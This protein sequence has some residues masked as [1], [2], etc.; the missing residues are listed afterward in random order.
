M[1]GHSID[2]LFRALKKGELSG[3]Y[4]LHG[5]E[6]LLKDEAIRTILDRALDPGLRDFNF[7]QRSA[8]QLDVEAVV[9]LCA[10]LPMMAD[11]RVVVIRDVEAWKRKPKVRA[12]LLRYLEK[13]APETILVLVQS[14][15]EEAED[16]ELG[17]RA[18]AVRFD[19]LPPDRALKWL[20]HHA[21]MLG[22]ALGQQGAEHLLRCVGGELGALA[23]ELQK[24]AA[25]PPGEPLT[26]ERVSELVGVRH[27]ETIFDWRDRVMDD[28]PAEAVTLLAPV[29]HQPGVSAVKLIA[30]LGTTLVG[31]GI[32]RDHYDR[33][34]RG[35]ALED[36]VFK[37]L[38]RNKVFG[39][40][41]Y[42]EEA[43]RWARWA[44]RWPADRVHAGLRATL[45]ADRALK[46][47]TISDE[48]AILTDLVMHLT[49]PF[50]RRV[51]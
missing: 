20:L 26:P 38:L 30:M 34:S 14:A 49:V 48:Q 4:Y 11:R 9:T 3:T 19:P 5:P 40:L 25:L 32:A 1:P 24:F 31:V 15:G 29:L 33:G 36:A 45:A 50:R 27:G 18:Y 43:P 17:R 13:P 7:D 28:Q 12:A 42:K 37:T 46:S 51:A 41:N 44:A 23:S 39:L 10:T 21:E 47:T 35:R 8:A 22:I 2:T 16:A 6:D